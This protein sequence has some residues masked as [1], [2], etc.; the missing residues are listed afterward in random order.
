MRGRIV[1][2]ARKDG[3]G[4]YRSWGLIFVFGRKNL[5]DVSE[6]FARLPRYLGRRERGAIVLAA[7]QSNRILKARYSVE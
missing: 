1:E 6:L 2:T 4:V 5:C 7:V 3:H